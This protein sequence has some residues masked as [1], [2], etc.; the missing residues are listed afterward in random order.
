[1]GVQAVEHIP[2]GIDLELQGVGKLLEMILLQA[3]VLELKADPTRRARGV[4][5]E[6]QIEQGRGVVATVLV[7]D[8]TLRIGD[9]FVSG[10]YQ[11]KVRAMVQRAG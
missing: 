11:G 10:L 5:I 7:Q 1:M 2:G 8:G 3:E 9:P 6:S 4:V